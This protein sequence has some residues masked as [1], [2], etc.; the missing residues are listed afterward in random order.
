MKILRMLFYMGLA[1]A[2]CAASGAL[3]RAGGAALAAA[4]AEALPLAPG[5]LATVDLDRGPQRLRFTPPTGSVYDLCVFPEAGK[6]GDVEV[7]LWQGDALAA[8]GRGRLTVVSERLVAGERYDI[9]LE[10][11]GR[12]RVE[13]ARHALSRCFGDPLPLNAAGD[14]YAKAVA[15]PGDVH[16]YSVTVEDSRPVLLS[17]APAEGG[18][19]LEAQLFGE[20]GALLAEAALTTGGAFLMDFMPRSG[21]TYRVRVCAPQGDAGMYA[22]TLTRS[23]GGLPEAVTLSEST[24]TLNG[25]ETRSLKAEISP[26]GAAAAL[27]WES[28]DPEVV[29][30]SADGSLTGRQAGTAVVTAY[31]AGNLRAR[32][33]VE[34][35]WVPVMGVRFITRRIDMNAGD[36][37]ALE[38]Q[39]IPENASAPGVRFVSYPAGVVEVDRGGVLRALSEGDTRVTVLTDEGVYRD[40]VAVHV[41]PAL[42]R[43]RALLVGE[44]GYA[45]SVASLRLGSA[46]SVAAL[47]SMLGELSFDGSRYAVDTRLDVSRDGALKAIQEAFDGATDQDV[48]LFY[49]TCHGYYS[50]GMTC[51]QMFDGSVL[52]AEELRMALNRVP[53]EILLMIDCCGSGGVIGR[54][55]QPQDILQGV[56]RVFS[57]V[58][59][60]GQFI[61]SRFRVLASASA[62][63]DSYRV[64]FS[65]DAAES[66]MATAFA[67]AL[68][69][70]G[71]WSVERGAAGPMRADANGDG[72]VGL[73]ELYSYV[74]RRVMWLLSLGDERYVQTVRVSPEGDARCVFERTGED[75][76]VYHE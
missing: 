58:T 8:S 24:V 35:R 54:A 19:R 65:E 2:L 4:S 1:T 52:T 61:A 60:P 75:D 16:W 36:D 11:A 7:R 26:E 10:G 59:G 44:Q 22:L 73:D 47:R 28:S 63:Q 15:R 43:Y 40:T 34:V 3:V 71:G 56:T 67:W 74:S 14:R 69:E 57:G 48:S 5:E 42:K 33:R 29:R 41:D 30:V 13:A 18:P 23:D 6:A 64:S 17:G 25:R 20:S 32:C 46:N 68:C 50:G 51:F 38:W 49:I 37:V 66:D 62:D 70:A 76:G 53:G 55:G 45:P 39:L 31:A 27:F 9:E 72:Q 12:V 21:Q